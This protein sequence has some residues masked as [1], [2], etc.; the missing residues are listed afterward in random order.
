[1]K[2]YLGLISGEESNGLPV[3]HPLRALALSN[4]PSQVSSN[5]ELAAKLIAEKNPSWLTAIKTRLVDTTDS[6]NASSALG[7]IRAYGALLET[8]MNITPGPAVPG[9]NVSPEFEV[10]HGDGAVIVEV[11]SR[12]LDSD[13]VDVLNNHRQELD[14]RHAVNV[15][16]ALSSGRKGSVVTTGVVEV[17]P[18]GAPTPGK[19]GDAVTTNA[20]SRIAS[21]KGKEH[22]IDPAKPFV[23]WL[24][25]QDETV[26]GIP[27]ADENFS[28]A[29]SQMN[30]GYV[31]AGIFW[32]ALYGRKGDPLL[33]SKGYNYDSMPLA[34]EGRFY[35]TIKGGP[36]R[37]S[38][39]I[40]SLPRA[41]VLMENPNA[42]HPLPPK[43]RAAILKLPFFRLDISLIDW[44]PGV[45]SSLITAQ[46]R[47]LVAAEGALKAFDF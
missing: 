36:S 47:A 15:Q 29:Y 44:E 9:S 31:D 19:A 14:A 34:H 6:A 17:F 16:Q 18:Y 28:P 4:P 40:F 41:T 5:T 38:A 25:L 42:P 23:L 22:Q 12:Q 45:V 20:I 11:H 1:M 21:V 26:W 27:V 10:S 46:R 33:L 43:F 13:Q 2:N 7:E 24:D 30:E 39:F 8:W 32:N 3:G 35:Q 37:V